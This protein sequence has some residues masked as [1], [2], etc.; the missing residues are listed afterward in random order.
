MD[1]GRTKFSRAN[2][3]TGEDTFA[4]QGAQ[5]PA[6]SRR[7]K[8][9]IPSAAGDLV[10]EA[11]NPTY[12][13]TVLTGGAVGFLH[14]FDYNNNGT[15]VS[16][17][18]AATATKLYK[19]TGGAFVEV[20]AV[21]TLTGYPQAV[22][23]DNL[24]HL[25]DGTLSWIFDG[26]GWTKAGLVIPQSQPESSYDYLLPSSQASTAGWVN[27]NAALQE[28]S[29]YASFNSTGQEDLRLTRFPFNLTSVTI[30]G[31]EV[32]V[33]GYG[34][35]A[36]AADRQIDVGMT[37][38]GTALAGTRKLAQQL[39]TT[40]GYLTL[41]GP[42]DLWGATWTT[43]E[44]NAETFGVLVRDADATAQPLYLDVVGV[45]IF[46]ET[47][48]ALQSPVI[49]TVNRFYWTTYADET[50]GRVHESSSSPRSQGTGAVTRDRIRVRQRRGV[51]TT[52]S[53]STAVNG[54]GTNF[55]S[56]DIGLILRVDGVNMGTISAV[57]AVGSNNVQS[58]TLAANAPSTKTRQYFTVAPTRATAWHIY[59]SESEN[60]NI[61]VYLTSVSI[62]T[63]EYV[64]ASPLPGQNGST[65]GDIERPIR[66]DPPIPSKLLT[67]HKH[68][69]WSRR[70]TQPNF[71]I[72]TAAEEVSAHD[73]GASEESAP[74]TDTGTISDLINEFGY[75]DESDVVR[76][77]CSHGDALYI[78]TEDEV[79][80]LYG[81]SFE[82]FAVSAVNAFGVGVAGRWA[83]A[84][85]PNGLAF[86]SYDKKV[87]LYPSFGVPIGQDVSA[88]LVEIGQPKAKTFESIK[89]ANLDD[90]RL[91]Y[92][93][94]GRRNWLVLCFL[95]STDVYQTWVFDFDTKGWFQLN[96]GVAS[97]GVFEVSA[98]KKVLL[99]GGSDGI[100]YVLDD[101]TGTYSSG[102]AYPEAI[103]RPA[104]IDFG[105]GDKK[106]IFRYV[107]FEVSNDVMPV[108]VT[109][110]LDPVNVDSPGAGIEIVMSKVRGSNLFRGF[111][112]F[113]GLCNY[114]LLEFKATSST[115]NGTLR[116]VTVAAEEAF[117][118]VL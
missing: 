85:T 5:N 92:Y 15:I 93:S 48:G 3:V 55:T 17:F 9:F 72:Y 27:G 89:A 49:I 77:F 83:M 32:R 91:K 103:Y 45:R 109:Y 47:S 22:N 31:I 71:I 46:Y 44:V 57:G 54:F 69:I 25:S 40:N 117:D 75:P 41:G 110:W 30:L 100:V 10:R 61:G 20:T 67:L 16:H 2:L 1:R 113:G 14:Q 81:E 33:K 73:N 84:S 80:P 58:V 68:R 13:S 79:L 39:G 52:A 70:E 74:G 56:A 105:A 88:L 106:H 118:L 112:K 38:D 90:V 108:T 102:S 64:D 97:L 114:L 60:S 37:K 53:G 63:M 29:S 65:F 115:Q 8:S 50:V 34:T 59:A 99:G 11:P 76:A 36:V 24:M 116:R 82:D 35:S 101:L 94:Y 66:N 4:S 62:S 111:P 86:V 43:A 78:A 107:E 6:T 42:T 19:V 95:D 21:G 104:L 23:H 18:F 87:Y 98:G 26:T 12:L 96:R 7:V 51:V 28:D